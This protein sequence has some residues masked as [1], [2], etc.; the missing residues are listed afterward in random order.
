MAITEEVCWKL[1]RR[2]IGL[3]VT[4]TIPDANLS[5]KVENSLKISD[6]EKELVLNYSKQEIED[7]FYFMEKRGYI[8]VLGFGLHAPRSIYKITDEGL[9]LAESNKFSN[10][11]QK[12][13]SN[14]LLDV[15]TP[16]MFG[17]KFNAGELWR[18]LKKWYRDN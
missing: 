4:Y 7:S 1:L 3:L 11:E 17:I 9:K 18:R 15:R 13:F 12:A 6:M 2:P 8:D 10:E 5:E 14:A 16:G